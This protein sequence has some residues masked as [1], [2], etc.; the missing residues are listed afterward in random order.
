MKASFLR[1]L[2][3]FLILGRLLFCIC[4]Y[5]CNECIE[6]LFCGDEQIHFKHDLVCLDVQLFTCISS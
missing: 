2:G 3:F 6:I 4:K 5:F 1:F